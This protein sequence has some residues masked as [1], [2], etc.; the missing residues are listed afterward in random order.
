MNATKEILKMMSEIYEGRG[1]KC[2]V[3]ADSLTIA[4]A[5]RRSVIVRNVADSITVGI[6]H[7]GVTAMVY[8]SLPIP[9]APIFPTL[10]IMPMKPVTPMSS[11]FR[12]V[13]SDVVSVDLND[14]E[15]FSKI[16]AAIDSCIEKQ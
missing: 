16:I 3:T 6:H 7:I 5:L 14:P 13:V 9:T 12:K 10:P 4:I 11:P 2:R 1:H 15:S 8:P